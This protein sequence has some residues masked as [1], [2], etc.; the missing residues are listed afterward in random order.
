[1]LGGLI[2]PVSTV[3]LKGQET[4]VPQLWCFPAEISELLKLAGLHKGYK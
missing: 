1:V 4:V 3:K 2:L